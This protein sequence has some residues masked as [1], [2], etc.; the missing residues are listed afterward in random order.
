MCSPYIFRFDILFYFAEKYVLSY[1]TDIDYNTTVVL[2]EGMELSFS[3]DT[4][5]PFTN[6]SFTVSACTSGG[7][8]S[9]LPVWIITQQAAPSG[10]TEPVVT[11]L[12]ADSFYIEWQPPAQPNGTCAI[13]S[14][15]Y[16]LSI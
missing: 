11:A 16:S 3:S 13:P 15:M 14:Y 8:L 5:T 2:F 1:S 10:Q 4:L 9:S 6:Y 7:C 12:S